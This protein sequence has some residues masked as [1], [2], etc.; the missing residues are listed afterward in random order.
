MAKRKK[1]FITLLVE[2][3]ELSAFIGQT[4]MKY[5]IE[6]LGGVWREEPGKPVWGDAVDLMRKN[7]VDGWLLAG[8]GAEWDKDAGRRGSVA[9]AA[10]RAANCLGPG[11]G[12]FTMLTPAP[13]HL[14]TPLAGAEAVERGKLGVRLAAKLGLASSPKVAPEYYF[15]VHPLPAGEGFVAEVGPA[16]GKEWRGALFAVA[17]GGEITHHAVGPR[18]TV[19]ERGVVEYPMQGVKLEAGGCEYVGWGVANRLT[20]GESYFLRVVGGPAR[21]LFGAMPEGAAADLYTV[22]FS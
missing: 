3:A 1:L 6:P 13:E 22:T 4:A 16:A 21:V 20:S 9:L 5:G 7:A 11:F 14:P 17:G 12:V 10:V 15:A 19:P 18:G 8:N 2:D